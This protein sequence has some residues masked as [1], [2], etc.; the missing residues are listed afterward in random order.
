MRLSAKFTAFCV[1]YSFISNTRLIHTDHYLTLSYSCTNR[2]SSL[3]YCLA[4]LLL[5]RTLAGDLYRERRVVSVEGCR[6]LGAKPVRLSSFYWMINANLIH[7]AP[8]S[9]WAFY[10]PL[11]GTLINLGLLFWKRHS[12]PLNLVLLGTFT[13]ME[14]FTLGIVTAF[15][16]NIIV[17]QALLITLGV[18]LGLTLYTLQAKVRSSC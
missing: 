5:I 12:H 17:L 9:S 13:A 4:K 15:Y 16:D 10:I 3:L 11:F 6:H 2:E 1:S 7:G 14:A 18:F 8:H